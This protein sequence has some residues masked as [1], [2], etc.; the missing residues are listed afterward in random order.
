MTFPVET[1]SL[2]KAFYGHTVFMDGEKEGGG[3]CEWVGGG[4]GGGGT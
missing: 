2:L 4:G 1:A 3:R